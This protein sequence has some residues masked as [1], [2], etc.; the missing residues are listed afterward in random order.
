MQ[1]RGNNGRVDGPDDRGMA[2]WLVARFC[3]VSLFSLR[4][5]HA[6]SKGGKTLLVP[7]PYSVKMALLDACFRRYDGI[8]ADNAARIV[9]DIVKAREVRIQPPEQC[10]VQNTFIRMLD[11]E[12]D[13]DLP[14]KRTI[15]YREFV[16]HHGVLEVAL[17]VGGLS[18]EEISR[19]AELFLHINSFGKRGSFWQFERSD[20][21]EGGL[22]VGFTVPLSEPE[23]RGVPSYATLQMLD[24]FGEALCAAPDG[25]D[26]VS[27]YG[28]GRIQLGEHR[29]LVPTALPYRR[30]S[31]GRSF[32]W[33]GR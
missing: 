4:M 13:G 32:T 30:L 20:R 22:P 5:T 3:P 24:D 28:N 16:S 26:R 18:E 31:A 12:R 17:G 23:I 33:Y 11:A 15:A 25:F 9:F 19:L 29:V 7:T 27:T 1:K 8:E 2:Q 21:L 10:V 14:F 6:T